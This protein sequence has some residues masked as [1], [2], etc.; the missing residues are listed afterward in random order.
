M[1]LLVVTTLVI[2]FIAH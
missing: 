2:E 1:Y